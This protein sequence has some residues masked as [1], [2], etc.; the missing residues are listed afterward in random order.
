MLWNSA[1][2]LYQSGSFPM[3]PVVP[4]KWELFLR[5]LNLSDSE[6]LEAISYPP[7]ETATRIKSWVNRNYRSVFVPEIILQT[8]GIETGFDA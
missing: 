6:A 2:G 5:E 3:S 7:N 8:M 4:A 1:F